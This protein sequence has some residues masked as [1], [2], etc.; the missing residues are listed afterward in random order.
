MNLR[1]LR[2]L[3]AITLTMAGPTPASDIIGDGPHASISSTVAH[4]TGTTRAI[5]FPDASLRETI[6]FLNRWGDPGGFGIRIDVSKLPFPVTIRVK[7]VDKNLS[8]LQAAAELAAQTNSNLQI[9]PGKIS[10]IPRPKPA[11]K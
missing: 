10:F 2:L 5:D 6:A 9:E 7:L 1:L 8:L 3:L 11:A 4:I